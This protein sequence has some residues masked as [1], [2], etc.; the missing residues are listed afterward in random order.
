MEKTPYSDKV[1]FLSPNK[2]KRLV[3]NFLKIIW[4]KVCFFLSA[5]G[6]FFQDSK[7]YPESLLFRLTIIFFDHKFKYF[8]IK[9]YKIFENFKY[10]TE[11]LGLNLYYLGW[12]QHNIRVYDFTSDFTQVIILQNMLIY[13][14]S[15]KVLLKSFEKILLLKYT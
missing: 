8:K 6:Q 1:I 14:F 3:D 10:L 13:F 9:W 15:V 11:I 12:R 7:N 4:N 5:T 2:S